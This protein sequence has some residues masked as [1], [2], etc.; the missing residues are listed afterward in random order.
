MRRDAPHRKLFA[1]QSGGKRAPSLRDLAKPKFASRM[2]L[3]PN[4]FNAPQ[5][6]LYYKCRVTGYDDKRYVE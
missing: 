5:I 3:D 2:S 4:P 6:T 1:T